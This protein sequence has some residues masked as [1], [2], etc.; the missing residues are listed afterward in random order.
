MKNSRLISIFTTAVLMFSLYSCSS[1]IMDMNNDDAESSHL[2]N[3]ADA[4]VAPSFNSSTQVFEN[5]R[6]MKQELEN[7]AATLYTVSSET[8]AFYELS[9]LPLGYVE[10]SV[11]WT[12]SSDYVIYYSNGNS[13]IAYMPITSEDAL[14]SMLLD[15]LKNGGTYEYLSENPLVNGVTKTDIL[16]TLGS[17]Y[18]CT[19]NTSKTSGL[20]LNYHEYT[21]EETDVTYIISTTYTNTGDILNS[22]LF[23]FNGSS[24][25]VCIGSETNIDMETACSLTSVP[26]S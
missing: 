13:V 18:E 3:S 2:H 16:S 11:E 14:D 22:K 17:M 20:K 26:N 8:P 19:Y 12:G 21:N 4:E 23:V 5:I 9:G 6:S 24:S 7:D 15:L 10:T 1:E 25:F